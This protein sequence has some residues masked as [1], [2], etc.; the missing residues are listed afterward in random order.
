MHRIRQS[1]NRTNYI[2]SFS[3]INRSS[4]KLFIF[5]LQPGSKIDVQQI[6]R[7]IKVNIKGN[8]KGILKKT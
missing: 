2:F 4:I 3:E 7:N 6:K 8:I 5:F 1:K